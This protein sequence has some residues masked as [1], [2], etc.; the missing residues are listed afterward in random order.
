MLLFGILIVML[1][2]LAVAA[3]VILGVGGSAFIIAFGDII[4]CIAI[5][6]WIIKR[7]I[8]KK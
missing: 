7:M 6:I 8:K 2:L 4:V 5:I 3:I 1:V